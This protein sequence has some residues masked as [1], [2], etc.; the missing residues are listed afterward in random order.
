MS[1]NREKPHQYRWRTH[2]NWNV[3]PVQEGQHIRGVEQI[4]YHDEIEDLQD[5]IES[6]PDWNAMDRFTTYLNLRSSEADLSSTEY[7]EL[8]PIVNLQKRD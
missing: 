4:V 1:Q 6:G 7:E 8:T 3:E 2:V 5:F